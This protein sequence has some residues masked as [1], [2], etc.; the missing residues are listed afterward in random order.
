MNISGFDPT[1]KI[2]M[3]DNTIKE[4]QHIVV[5]DLIWEMTINIEQ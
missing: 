5:G 1:T 2:L 4:I 3:Y